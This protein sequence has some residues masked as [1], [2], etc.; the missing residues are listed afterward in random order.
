ML[1]N[2]SR[3]FRLYLVVFHRHF[4]PTGGINFE[5]NIESIS[6]AFWSSLRLCGCSVCLNKWLVEPIPLDPYLAQVNITLNFFRDAAK[7]FE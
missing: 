7:I 3:N 5:P 6:V 4:P 2:S 1:A